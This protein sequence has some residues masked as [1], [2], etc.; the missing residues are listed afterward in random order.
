MI[1][2][3]NGYVSTFI[4]IIWFMWTCVYYRKGIFSSLF[5]GTGMRSFKSRVFG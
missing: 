4:A 3:C 1:H 2:Q 5:F